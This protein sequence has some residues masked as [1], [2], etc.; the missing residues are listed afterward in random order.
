MKRYIFVS[1]WIF[2]LAISS[3]NASVFVEK[4]NP[5]DVRVIKYAYAAEFKT[6][7]GKEVLFGLINIRTKPFYIPYEEKEFY[8]FSEYLAA[9]KQ[10]NWIKGLS[11]LD[12]V[13][14]VQLRDFY[15]ILVNEQKIEEYYKKETSINGPVSTHFYVNYQGDEYLANTVSF[16]Y[17]CPNNEDY[18]EN[19]EINKKGIAALRKVEIKFTQNKNQGLSFMILFNKDGTI[20]D[21]ASSMNS[22]KIIL[23]KE[24]GTI[25]GR[26]IQEPKMQ[27][28]YEVYNNADAK[29]AIKT[30]DAFKLAILNREEETENF[31]SGRRYDEVLYTVMKTVKMTQ[32]KPLPDDRVLPYI[33]PRIP[34]T[35]IVK[36]EPVKPVEPRKDQKTDR[37]NTDQA[38]IVE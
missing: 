10:T 4:I 1:L 8:T 12:Y 22:K 28:L 9:I 23:V 16:S 18:C 34:D 31:R 13:K 29:E 38:A 6:G 14:E 24:S 36:V 5:S 17:Y 35:V 30:V 33:P 26:N 37:R 19:P 7:E 27:A 21:Q 15:E 3:V 11:P 2:L 20:N 32:P 25:D